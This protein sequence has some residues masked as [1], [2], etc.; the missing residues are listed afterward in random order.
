MFRR[1]LIIIVLGFSFVLLI[2]VLLLFLGLFLCLLAFNFCCLIV[3]TL[4]QVSGCLAWCQ[5]YPV[6]HFML[7]WNLLRS[8]LPG[9]TS[10]HV[11]FL[12]SPIIRVVAIS[13]TPDEPWDTMP[14]TLS[15]A[16]SDVPHK[17]LYH[18]Q[19]QNELSKFLTH[20]NLGLKSTLLTLT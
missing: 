6:T 17:H 7:E 8:Q 15:R 2:L 3:N 14:G 18:I 16:I 11:F 4:V 19:W 10:H 9:R 12:Y 1:T 20:V 5:R 13:I